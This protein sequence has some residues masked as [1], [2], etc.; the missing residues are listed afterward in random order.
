MRDAASEI[1]RA[2]DRIDDPRRAAFACWPGLALFA[3]EP[4]AWKNLKQAL[5]DERL[6]LAVHLGEKVLRGP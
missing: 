6:R 4:I 5:S 1:R 2:V 3:D